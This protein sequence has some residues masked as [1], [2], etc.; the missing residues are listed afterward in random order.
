MSDQELTRL[1]H[2]ALLTLHASVGEEIRRR[3]LTRTS[4]NPVA[5]LAER[6][7]ARALALTLAQSSTTG[8][9]AVDAAGLRYEIKARRRT[10]RSKPT[11][12]SAL[13]SLEAKHFDRL[14]VLLLDEDYSVVRASMLPFH[15]VQSVARYRK[16]VNAHIL[17]LRDAWAAPE[18][19][20]I[21]DRCRKAWEDGTGEQADRVGEALP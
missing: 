7:A 17:S 1:S 2:A 13:R 3:G 18:A 9:E 19:T 14:V 5:D 10:S 21:T 16:D 11:H 6:L 4:N 15:A 8:Y 20:D 12:L